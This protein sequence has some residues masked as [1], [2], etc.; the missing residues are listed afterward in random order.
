V[1]GDPADAR[2]ASRHRTDA[3]MPVVDAMSNR[4]VGFLRDVSEGGLQLVATRPL[5]DDALY[6]VLFELQGRDGLVTIEAGVQLVN[7]RQ[8]GDDIVAGMRFIHLDAGN[9][10]RLKAWLASDGAPSR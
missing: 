1:I 3:G 6:Q 9:S 5:V 8:E 7:H 10:R 4:A 2:R